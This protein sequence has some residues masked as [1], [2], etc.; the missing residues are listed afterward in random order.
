MLYEMAS[1]PSRTRVTFRLR[2]DLAANLRQLPNQTRFVEDAL[3][4]ALGRLCPLCHGNG[5]APDVHLAVSDLRKL[6]VRRLDRT[7]A[8]WLK[9]LV[10]LGR[11][12]L[13]TQLDLEPTG[14]DAALGFRLARENHVLLAG[15]IPRG[16]G[17]VRLAH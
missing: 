17:G 5:T 10:R 14:D 16:P 2:R 4:E 15:S 13:A 1:T 9:T 11:E 7:E 8:A 6:Q 12:L 3:Q